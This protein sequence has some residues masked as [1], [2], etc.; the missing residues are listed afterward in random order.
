[1]PSKKW[2][3]LMGKSPGSFRRARASREPAA[4]ILI[5]TEG[6]VSEPVYFKEL[7]NHMK[8]PTVEMVVEP[9]GMG[10]PQRLAERACEISEARRRSAK[11]QKLGISQARV[12][13]ELWIVFDT[14]APAAQGRLAG[15]L[16]FAKERGVKCAHSTPCFEFWLLLHHLFSTAPMRTC[17]EVIRR[18]SYAIGKPYTKNSNDSAE[19]I[20]PMVERIETALEHARGV[21]E[22]HLAG[23][24]PTPA[25]PSTEVDLLVRSIIRASNFGPSHT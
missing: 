16:S 11:R 3:K 4:A 23:D 2:Q 14:D 7:R 5:V 1:M 18:L 17:A 13:D 6:Q 24:S 9:A 19:T 10:D 20:P 12:F 25:N 22:Y 8:L 21:R 15:G